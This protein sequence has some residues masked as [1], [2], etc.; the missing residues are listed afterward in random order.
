MYKGLLDREPLRAADAVKF[1]ETRWDPTSSSELRVCSSGDSEFTRAKRGN[2]EMVK[3][4][5]KFS[6]LL[7]RLRE[8]W[9][10]Y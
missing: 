6:L 5:G 3:M 2:V 9:M 10:E 4:I 7:K 1:S 8:A